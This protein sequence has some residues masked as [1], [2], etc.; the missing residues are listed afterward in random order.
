VTERVQDLGKGMLGTGIKALRWRCG[1]IFREGGY[2]L[3]SMTFLDLSIEI[4][5]D[6][7]SSQ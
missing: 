6:Y 3:C 4:Y 2:H 7:G 1:G 5:P